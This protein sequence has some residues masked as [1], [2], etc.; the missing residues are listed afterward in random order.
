MGPV[1]CAN[2]RA[3]LEG[4]HTAMVGPAVIID[5]VDP[6]SLIGEQSCIL[7]HAYLDN[8]C[9]SEL[10]FLAAYNSN[11]IIVRFVVLV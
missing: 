6:A 7:M 1:S 4:Q 10:L 11:F 2:Q 8:P 9:T 3:L 5:D